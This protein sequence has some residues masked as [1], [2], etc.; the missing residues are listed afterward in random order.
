MPSP[1]M[2]TGNVVLLPLELIKTNTRYCNNKYCINIA[3]CTA[4]KNV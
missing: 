1:A 4:V 3:D 2:Q